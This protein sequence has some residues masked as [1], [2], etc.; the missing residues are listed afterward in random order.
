MGYHG[1]HLVNAF[2]VH[3]QAVFNVLLSEHQ[4]L[5]SLMDVLFDFPFLSEANGHF[6]LSELLLFLHFDLEM[7]HL[8]LQVINLCAQ[9]YAYYLLLVLD[10]RDDYFLLML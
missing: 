10:L 6:V 3:F 8:G 2:L 5:F 4:A 1:L 9:L 7:R